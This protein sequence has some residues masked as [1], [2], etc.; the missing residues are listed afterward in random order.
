M[1]MQKSMNKEPDY[2]YQFISIS[3][4]FLLTIYGII[5]SLSI[6]VELIIKKCGWLLARRAQTLFQQW[7]LQTQPYKGMA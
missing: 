5:D 6:V 1:I 2:S 3:I 4:G 7:A